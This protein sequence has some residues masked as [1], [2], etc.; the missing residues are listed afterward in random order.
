[1]AGMPWLHEALA[2]AERTVK[3]IVDLWVVPIEASVQALL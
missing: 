3:V 2:M 1:M